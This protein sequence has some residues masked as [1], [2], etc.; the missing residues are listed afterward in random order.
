MWPWRCTVARI[1]RWLVLF[2]TAVLVAGWALVD[3]PHA[4]NVA[5]A[6]ERPASPQEVRSIAFDGRQLPLAR[7]RE[8]LETHPGDAL[9]RARLERDRAA[10]AR[11]LAAT[12]YLA[13]QVAPADV[14]FDPAGAVYITFEI[15]KGPL[16]HLRKVD[17]RGPGK[18]AA[19]VTIN[20]GDDAIRAR[21]ERARSSLSDG[22]ARR[23]KPAAVGLD[24]E[25]DRASAAV[26]V[27]LTTR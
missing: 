11:E 27:V 15:D 2:P 21:L 3:R 24:V 26:D 22:L 20:P 14:T 13:A 7:L 19:V 16:F 10:M 23:G 8:L 17:V 9:D 6:A 1:V 5:A 18:D 12:G 25:V 4:T